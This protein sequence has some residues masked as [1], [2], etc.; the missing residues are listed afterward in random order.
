ME[1]CEELKMREP[2]PARP[3]DVAQGERPLTGMDSRLWRT[4]S[5]IGVGNDGGGWKRGWDGLE[6]CG[7]P[8][9]SE[10]DGLG[11]GE[12]SGKMDSCLR[13]NDGMG[14]GVRRGGGGGG[15]GAWGGGSSRPWR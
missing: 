6:G 12:F 11:V 13:R 5:P 7:P 14:W 10:F 2:P 4:Y 8:P 3:F 9:G 1:L 15:R